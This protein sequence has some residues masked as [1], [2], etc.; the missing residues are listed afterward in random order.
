MRGALAIVAALF[1]VACGGSTAAPTDAGRDAPPAVPPESC[2]QRGDTGNDLGVGTFC[3]PA[4]GECSAFPRAG[5]CLAAVAP[6]E[7]Q[8][9]CTRLCM[10]D[11]QCGMDALCVGDGRGAA[12][13]P[14]RCAPD[15][16]D[17]GPPG[18]AG[19]SD[20]GASDAG[21]SDASMP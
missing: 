17:G 19:T 10:T 11:D 13:V 16:P 20:A 2:A 12:C 14:A 8:W 4:G 18:D 1:S 6:E 21:A 5:L 9:F 3:T 7:R 15:R